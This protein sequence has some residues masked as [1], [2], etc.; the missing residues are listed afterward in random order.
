MK[1]DS[2]LNLGKIGM[3]RDSH[4]SNLKEHSYT[5]ALNANVVNE[6]GNGNPILQSEHSNIL[7]YKFKDGYQ[8][9]GFKKYRQSE[10]VY[11]FL[12]NPETKRSRIG[13]L[14]YISYTDS[15][16]LEENCGCNYQSILAQPLEKQQQ[17][18][19]CKYKTIASDECCE[20]PVFKFDINYPIFPTNIIIKEEYCGTVMYFT[21][22]KNP[23]RYIKLSELDSYRY[24]DVSDCEEKKE[25]PTL[26]NCNQG[27][28]YITC[29]DEDRLRI[30]KFISKLCVNPVSVTFGG[31][32]TEG[33]Y[34]VLG[35]YT[36]E[37]GE[38]LSNYYGL[39]NPIS[40]FNDLNI[41]R[42]GERG[43]FTTNKS[44]A[45]NVQATDRN[46]K[47]YKLAIIHRSAID[48]SIS[49]YHTEPKPVS[50]KNVVIS[51]V[52]NLSKTSLENL[53]TRK[54]V[55]ERTENLTASNGYLFHT[56]LVAKKEINLQPVF[57][58]IGGLIK[59]QT[60]E[61]DEDLYKDGVNTSLYKTYMRDEVYVPTIKLFSEDSHETYLFTLPNRPPTA[62]DLEI[63]ANTDVESLNSKIAS[64]SI[65]R[66]KR[67]QVY[68]T[69]TNDGS[70]PTKCNVG[71]AV[72]YDEVEQ[73]SIEKCFR[74]VDVL[75]NQTFKIGN[76]NE[77]YDI[78]DYINK[79]R[80]AIC[81]SGSEFYDANLCA[82]LNNQYD[83]AES[84]FSD[85]YIQDNCTLDVQPITSGENAPKTTITEL[86]GETKTTL[87]ADPTDAS[88]YKFT[89]KPEGCDDIE[90]NPIDNFNTNLMDSMLTLK[91]SSTVDPTIPYVKLEPEGWIDTYKQV[92]ADNGIYVLNKNRPNNG[93]KS[94]KSSTSIQKGEYGE[95]DTFEAQAHTL[96]VEYAR[97]GETKE[98]LLSSVSTPTFDESIGF[99]DKINKG[100]SWFKFPV[101]AI[102]SQ[103]EGKTM[104][105][106][107]GFTK[108]RVC[109]EDLVSKG[110]KIRISFFYEGCTNTATES[111]I[112]DPYQPFNKFFDRNTM[113]ISGGFVYVA[114]EGQVVDGGLKEEVSFPDSVYTRRVEVHPHVTTPCGCFYLDYT[115]PIITGM[116]ITVGEI[117]I[118]KEWSFNKTC[119]VKVPKN[120]VC[121]V[122]PYEYGDFGYYESKN[123]YPCNDELFD[124]SKLKIRT[125]QIPT[126]YLDKFR[127]YYT[128]GDTAG[129]F[130][131]KGDRSTNLSGTPLRFHRFPDNN[132][133]P[134][135]SNQ[136][137][138]IDFLPSKIYP[139]GFYIDSDL[140]NAA[141]DIA[142]SNDLISEEERRK[143]TKFEV[144]VGDRSIHKSVIAKG[145]G[146][147]MYKYNEQVGGQDREF[148]YPN[149]PYNDLGSDRYNLVREGGSP[150]PHP[151][152]GVG[153]SKFTMHSPDL[154]YYK[155]SIPTEIKVDGYQFGYSSGS[156]NKVR[157]H[158][159]WVILEKFAYTVA[160]ALASAEVA[161]NQATAIAE[162]KLENARNKSLAETL[163]INYS[164]SLKFNLPSKP[165]VKGSSKQTIRSGRYNDFRVKKAQT[166]WTIIQ[167][168]QRVLFETGKLRKQYLDIIDG[169]GDPKNFAYYYTSHGWYNRLDKSVEGN[170]IRSISSKYLKD[171]LLSF[172]ET[173]GKSLI[174]NNI[175][176][177]H[178]LYLNTLNFDINYPNTYTKWDNGDSN[179]SNSSRFF[180]SES[181]SCEQSEVTI[182]RNIA[183]PYFS[184]K[185]W[186]DS[187]Y[188][189]LYDI[190]F[191]NTGYCGDLSGKFIG[192]NLIY[193]GDT[194]ISRFSLK[195]KMPF[196]RDNAIGL[197]PRTPFKYTDYRNIGFPKYYVDYRTDT[198]IG[199]VRMLF[200]NMGTK[201]SMDCFKRQN[202]SYLKDPAKI[203]LFSYGIP[204]FL[205]ESSINNN[206]RTAKKLPEQN[207]Y[208]NVGDYIEWTQEKTV[209]IRKP[210]TFYYNDVFSKNTSFLSD[211]LIPRTFNREEY[212]CKYY[213]PSGVINSVQDNSEKERRDAWLSYKPLDKYNFKA[214]LGRLISFEDIESAQV[215]GRFEH[216]I[217]LFN[218]IDIIKE[219]LTTYKPSTNLGTG[220]IFANRPIEYKSTDLGYAGTQ[221]KAMVSCEFGHFWADSKRGQVFSVNQNGK[222]LKEIT[223]GLRQWFKEQLPFK[224]MDGNI[225]EGLTDLDLDKPFKNLGIS[226]G[227][228]SRFRRVFLTK[229]DYKVREQ[230][231][232]RL[233]YKDRKF[234]LDQNEIQLTDESIFT[235]IRWT[236]AYSPIHKTWISYYSF[237]PNYYI[238]HNN[239]FKTGYS[240]GTIWNHL[241]TNKSYRVFNGIKYKWGVEVI[242]LERY[243]HKTF[244]DANYWMDT[245]RYHND[246]DIAE[247]RNAGFDTVYVYNNSQNSGKVSLI[248][249][250]KNNLFQETKYPK[251]TNIGSEVLATCEDSHW[252]YNTIFNRVRNEYNN[253]P[254]WQHDESY[255][256]KQIN[257]KAIGSTNTWKDR[258]KGDWFKIRYE[259][260]G[261]TRFKQIFKW[262]EVRNL[263][264]QW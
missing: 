148:L 47:Y 107:A 203:Y 53:T 152:G 221:H 257:P 77:Y 171:G 155:P 57:N 237:T 58:L 70:L 200:T 61:A 222:E 1:E 54:A 126:Q 153:N 14:T 190:Q 93:G 207:F 8:V 227:W 255:I 15:K 5:W 127:E 56:G 12:S 80:Q 3:D 173:G 163:R 236:V 239:Y 209:S 210:N 149:Y 6:S 22:F 66:D 100:A 211:T 256:N 118:A 141:L 198:S 185:N 84:C 46:F 176:R 193:G 132:I 218:A 68:N 225:I 2:K 112:V 260:Y 230:Y 63:V 79:N 130:N 247:K 97:E 246:Y 21:D 131:L 241:I 195:R 188:G 11:L 117:K 31:N 116:T 226:M 32:L 101:N 147:D 262:N 212:D 194:F 150:I 23:S 166:A 124:S 138:M 113:N 122:T 13:V 244:I 104:F 78:T 103:M 220:G 96:R 73:K 38:E 232:G 219:R 49:Y 7:C 17:V 48:G 50:N 215:L 106:F 71:T 172:S 110:D 208:P 186:N 37:S 187:Q 114:I 109:S 83:T 102:D 205:V 42:H 9:V 189:E 160:T 161:F 254:I 184:L 197:A 111:I 59:W 140:I 125:D 202:V 81:Q 248:P 115:D 242:D 28:D 135:M 199:G 251:Y 167:T 133:S 258:L 62:K 159:K 55:Y 223:S 233:T 154:S 87:F 123:N 177:E 178:S 86:E 24:Y 231:R 4:P 99:Y 39:T 228:D 85:I 16:D 75:R 192:C 234:Y 235:P 259:T 60:S 263:I 89:D 134:F 216:T 120:K 10:D 229:L 156:F 245:I 43:E 26:P 64:C 98:N 76:P 19:T 20:K 182:K 121:G 144:F 206:F 264:N 174:I 165:P 105:R 18:E 65:G 169:L 45:V 108:G 128:E 139:I 137:G 179:R 145:L 119:T 204:Q 92:L 249:K 94:C 91:V 72:E 157:G 142:V 253:I 213:E 261:D 44:I 250:L 129:I 74:E 240:D 41:V 191:R 51:N 88:S 224:I 196:F 162:Q 69:A 151:N 146:F 40:I 201:K 217:V 67:W 95:T 36:D 170:S 90:G 252:S 183:S 158:S 143:I 164:H 33:T 238:P 34:E 175:N 35:V 168:T 29:I 214:S 52:A 243:R 30:F 25:I 181:K 136:I 180:S 82:I 27:K